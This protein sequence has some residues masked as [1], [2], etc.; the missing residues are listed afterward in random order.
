MD[1]NYVRITFWGYEFYIEAS[2]LKDLSF[3][4]NRLVNTSN[5]SIRM[6]N[7][8]RDQY[9]YVVC[10]SMSKCILYGGPSYNME[11]DTNYNLASGQKF[12][13]NTLGSNGF[14][15]MFLML[16]SLIVLFKL[17]WKK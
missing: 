12:N 5:S 15:T 8:F 9:P 13:I 4:Q 14:N 11:I 16:I 6:V 3:I 1:D 7:S 2:R 10:N 17:I